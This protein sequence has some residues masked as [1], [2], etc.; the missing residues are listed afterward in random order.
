MSP[1]DKPKAGKG[2]VSPRAKLAG[3]LVIGTLV[4]IM[5][6]VPLLR[7]QP[8]QGAMKSRNPTQQGVWTP[9][10]A[11][12]ERNQ[13]ADSVNRPQLP[14]Q[15]GETGGNASKPP[16]PLENASAETSSTASSRIRALLSQSNAG[17]L[18]TDVGSGTSESSGSGNSG[19]PPVPISPKEG[20]SSAPVEMGDGGDTRKPKR[21]TPQQRFAEQVIRARERAFLKAITSK[22]PVNVSGASGSGTSTVPQ[23]SST[24]QG[25]ERERQAIAAERAHYEQEYQDAV[26]Q[27]RPAGTGP[28]A[29]H[30]G[31]DTGSGGPF[32]G[33]LPIGRPGQIVE[34]RL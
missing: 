26:H 3:I 5:F 24:L 17:G 7:K 11:A 28:T 2:G 14:S 30:P 15:I 8:G 34:E 18:A 23:I 13:G 9:K 20:W 1:P 29:F 32:I 12:A 10:A 21:M 6:V 4:I 33:D 25:L 22:I 16:P 19:G 27:M 31:A